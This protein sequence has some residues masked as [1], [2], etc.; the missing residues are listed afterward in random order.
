MQRIEFH[1][2]NYT[3]AILI[4]FSNR[5]PPHVC[6]IKFLK[7]SKLATTTLASTSTTGNSRRELTS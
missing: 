7:Y 3:K 2:N 1:Q 4:F 5:Q 6:K